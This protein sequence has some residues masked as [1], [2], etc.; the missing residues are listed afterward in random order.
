MLSIGS[1][2][3]VWT[4]NRLARKEELS[5]VIQLDTLHPQDRLTAFYIGFVMAWTGERG[6]LHKDEDGVSH[7]CTKK[8]DYAEFMEPN[9]QWFREDKELNGAWRMGIDLGWAIKHQ[10]APAPGRA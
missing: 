10:S 1:D 2:V 9:N 3:V 7:P 8:A 4:I 5:G 6:Y